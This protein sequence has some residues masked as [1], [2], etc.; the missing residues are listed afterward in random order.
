MGRPAAPR[1]SARPRSG[2]GGCRRSGSPLRSAV[3]LRPEESRSR[4][5]DL[6]RPPQLEVLPLELL[7]PPALLGGE[8]LAFAA[9]DLGLAQPVTDA[10]GVYAKLSAHLPQAAVAATPSLPPLIDHPDRALTQLGWIP[11]R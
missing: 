2:S 11:P 1:R 6:I 8:A 10:L 3:E 7:D 9:V 5:E 4:L